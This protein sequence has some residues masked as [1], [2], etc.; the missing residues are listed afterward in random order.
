MKYQGKI[1]QHNAQKQKKQQQP[2]EI[3][4]DAINQVEKQNEKNG[5]QKEISRLKEYCNAGEKFPIF[6]WNL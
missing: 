6:T 2:R 4:S 1:Q 3:D 5:K